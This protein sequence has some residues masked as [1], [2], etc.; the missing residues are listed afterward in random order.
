MSSFSEHLACPFVLWLGIHPTDILSLKID[1]K[2]MSRQDFK[3]I[4][5]L[6]K[7]SY[8]QDNIDLKNQVSFK[9]TSIY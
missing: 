6:L 4:D 7:R 5:S 8:I 1:S 9:Q 2:K 3:K